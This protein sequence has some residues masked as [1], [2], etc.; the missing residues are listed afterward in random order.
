MSEFD[1]LASTFEA[2]SPSLEDSLVLLNQAKAGDDDAM[3]RLLGRYQERLRRIVRVRMGPGIGQ[4]LESMDI[5]QG[6]NQVAWRKLASIEVRG[7]GSI[8]NWLAR[9][10]ERQIQ[11]AITHRQAEKRDWRREVNMQGGDDSSN[12]GLGDKLEGDASQPP[13]AA[14]RAELP[15]IIDKALSELSET[16]REAIVLRDY[17]GG[18][19][20]EIATTLDKTVP[21]VRELHRRA[22]LKLALKLGPVL[23]TDD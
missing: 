7:S 10:A 13:D 3:N 16:H 6:T 12:G 1:P 23:G 8:L 19:W 17:C 22:R 4:Y 20:D 5:V 9:V 11:D 2:P 18:E 21:A 14:E 15:E